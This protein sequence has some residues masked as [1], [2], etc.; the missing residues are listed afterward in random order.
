MKAELAADEQPFIVADRIKAKKADM[1]RRPRR[2]RRGWISWMRSSRRPLRRPMRRL[3]A[4]ET[5][6]SAMES[7]MRTLTNAGPY[8]FAGIGAKIRRLSPVFR[9]QA[10]GPHAR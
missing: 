1:R 3:T 8:G 7:E 4:A 6:L 10:G 5:D 9:L 2:G